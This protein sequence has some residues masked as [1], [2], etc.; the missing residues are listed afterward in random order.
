[1][2]TE[3]RPNASDL[4]TRVSGN[5]RQHMDTVNIVSMELAPLIVEAANRMLTALLSDRK[6][7]AW[8]LTLNTSR[9]NS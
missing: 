5:F 6:V 2:T 9:P 1:M 8:P 4:E 7:L 3:S